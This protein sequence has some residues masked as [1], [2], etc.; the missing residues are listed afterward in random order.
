M[1]TT[2]R[3]YWF[4]NQQ[5]C[6]DRLSDRNKSCDRQVTRQGRSEHLH[7]DPHDRILESCLGIKKA[8]GLFDR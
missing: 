3:S 4:D 2:Y 5:T 6:L 1:L 7:P 8:T